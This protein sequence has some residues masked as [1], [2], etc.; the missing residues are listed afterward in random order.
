[1]ANAFFNVPIA[2]NEVVREYEKN[3]LERKTLLEE[4]KKMYNKHVDIPMYIG[5]EKIYTKNKRNLTPP[6]DH[7][8]IIG[9]S[10]YG[11][12]K[13]VEIAIDAAMKAKSKWSNMKWEN[14]RNMKINSIIS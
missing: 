2:I 6:H 14:R 13:E 1:M 11:G 5:H 8:H 3:S 9:T 7:Q 12:E 4:Y 10:N